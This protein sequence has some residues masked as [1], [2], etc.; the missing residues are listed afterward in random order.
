MKGKNRSCEKVKKL[1][2]RE[3]TVSTANSKNRFDEER[4]EG[5]E[6]EY[7]QLVRGVTP[8]VK[9]WQNRDI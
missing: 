6:G 5:W 3:N 1:E 9:S 8:W 7:T 2:V 4:E